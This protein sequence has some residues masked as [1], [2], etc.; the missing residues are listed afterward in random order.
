MSE[1]TQAGRRYPLTVL[2]SVI[3][4]NVLDYYDFLLFAHMGYVITSYF[5]PNLSA[6]DTHLLGLLL[7]SMPF[8]IR[9]VGGYIF[10]KLSDI[11]GRQYALGE[12]L[13]YASI[14]S[15]GIALLPSYEYGGMVCAWAFFVLR[16]MQGLSLGGEY[17]TAGTFL[18]ERYA[19]RQGLISGILCASGTVGSLFAFFFSWLYLHEYLTGNTWRIAFLL[20]GIGSFISFLL[21]K[22]LQKLTTDNSDKKHEF[23]QSSYGQAVV[24]TGL[25][26]ALVGV[27]CW[28]P[29]VYSNFYLT[30]IMN[31]PLDYGLK[32][33]LISLVTYIFLNPIVGLLAD[34]YSGKFIMMVGALL[35]IPFGLA[36][37]YLIMQGLIV[38]Q[39]LLTIVPSLFGAPIHVVMNQVFPKGK[40]SRSINTTF[41]F[42][43]SL[44]GL[45][46]FIS[47]YFAE[48]HHFYNTPII[49]L[50]I[51]SVLTFMAFYNNFYKHKNKAYE[52]EPFIPDGVNYSGSSA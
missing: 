46:P 24:L 39:I 44:G 51:I 6:K 26:G 18:M 1:A 49:L 47:G 19:S 23:I 36:G 37:Y 33:T 50:V 27:S 31:L 35:A 8:V 25:I 11:R 40:R 20:G 12:T 10:G 13:K 38:G 7:F 32:A 41:M 52:D 45:T 5:V 17:T 2:I 30:K 21:R 3:T 16:S 34:R 48:H 9:P 43:T 28:L 14:A 15:F 22:R 29:M 4:G 42:G